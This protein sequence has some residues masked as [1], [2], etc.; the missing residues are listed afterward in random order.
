[1]WKAKDEYDDDFAIKRIKIHSNPKYI[2]AEVS[3]LK[4]S[5]HVNIPTYIDS[6]MVNQKEIWLVMEYIHGIDVYNLSYYI[7]LDPAE[8]ATICSGVLSALAHLHDKQIIHRD[9]KGEN[10]MVS[11]NGHIYLTDLG[12]SV[13]EGPDANTA[14]GTN[15]FKAPEMLIT[16]AYKCNADVWSLGMTIVQMITGHHPY[17]G[18]STNDV[19]QFM[20]DNQK[21]II[22]Q[23]MPHDMNDFLNLCLEWVAVKRSSASQLL[24]HDYLHRKITP[25]RLGMLVQTAQTYKDDDE[26]LER[27]GSPNEDRTTVTS[28][29]NL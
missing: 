25:E 2:L 9:V 4:Q 22:C 11:N 26:G 23:S 1:M 14:A 3:H 15:R 12:L 29:S 27:D 18:Y 17:H 28:S 16:K 5:D 10:I 8:I 7:T 19:L 6:F 20:I 13:L 24:K 21:P